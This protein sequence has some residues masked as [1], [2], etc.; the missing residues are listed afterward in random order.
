VVPADHKR[1]T[2]LAVVAAVDEGLRG[3][4]LRYPSVPPEQA[5]ALR[6]R[7]GRWTRNEAREDEGP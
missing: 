2:R 1:F 3:L 7:G 4:G 6:Q 5:T